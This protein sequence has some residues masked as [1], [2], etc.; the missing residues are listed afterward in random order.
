MGSRKIMTGKISK[1][2]PDAIQIEVPILCFVEDGIHFVNVPALDITGYGGNEK[3][4]KESLNIML[5]EFFDYA[6]RNKTL[7]SELKKLGWEKMPPPLM[8]SLQQ[9][10]QLQNI[11]NSKSFR[12][13]KMDMQVPAH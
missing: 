1:K 8:T 6:A 7:D 2:T 3:E 13:D 12:R 4:A 9:N 10:S 5:K 11:I